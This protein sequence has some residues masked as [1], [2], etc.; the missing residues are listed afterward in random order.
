MYYRCVNLVNIDIMADTKKQ[1]QYFG[2]TVQKTPNYLRAAQIVIGI[3]TLLLASTVIVYPGLAILV[4]VVWLSVSL[5]FGGIESLVIGASAR[6]LSKGWRAIGIITG[7]ITI[8]LSFAVLA[9]PVAGAITA[10]VLLSIGLLFLGSGEIA[11][12]V[13][14]KRIPGWTRAMLVGV[15]AITVGLSI[16]V[17]VSP[18]I[19]LSALYVLVATALIITGASYITAGVTG[20]VFRPVYP[21]LDGAR[22]KSWESEAT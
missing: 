11:R 22:K 18:L 7:A 12:G 10:F 6:H 17:I 19:A 5:L 20:A 3:I 15:G 9:H 8:G 16:A 2:G 21:T 13:S 1:P 14:E 4:A